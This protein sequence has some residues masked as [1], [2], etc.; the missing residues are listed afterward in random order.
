MWVA[1]L[2]GTVEE[3][4]ALPQIFIVVGRRT[5]LD[6]DRLKSRNRSIERYQRFLYSLPQS[7]RANAHVPAVNHF[8]PGS[9]QPGFKWLTRQTNHILYNPGQF[10]LGTATA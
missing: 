4:T 1:P 2:F 9:N 6:A 8:P 3:P 7:G 5:W 10:E